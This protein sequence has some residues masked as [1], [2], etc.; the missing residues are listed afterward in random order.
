MALLILHL[1]LTVF[2]L[3]YKILTC[4]FFGKEFDG[5]EDRELLE[6]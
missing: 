1:L 4:F 3:L 6:N 2:H 5:V